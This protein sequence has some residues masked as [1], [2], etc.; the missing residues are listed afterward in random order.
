[1]KKTYEAPEA[2]V[3][4]YTAEDVVTTSGTVDCQYETTERV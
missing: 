3:M 4:N 2:V 1:M